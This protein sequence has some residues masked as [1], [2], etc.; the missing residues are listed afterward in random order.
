MSDR[1][2][3]IQFIFKKRLVRQWTI[4]FSHWHQEQEITFL[5]IM[6]MKGFCWDFILKCTNVELTG[7]GET[8]KYCWENPERSSLNKIVWQIRQ[9]LSMRD[10]F[11]QLQ[12]A[13][14]MCAP[15]H[16]SSH[17]CLH[18]QGLKTWFDYLT[19]LGTT[20][21]GHPS[22]KTPQEVV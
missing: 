18:F 12:R 9:V 11:L 2:H 20:Q 13:H 21:K 6:N 1:P 16:C 7:D 5:K 15:S 14:S 4:F 19:Q 10:R 3:V 22:S 17:Q 8:G